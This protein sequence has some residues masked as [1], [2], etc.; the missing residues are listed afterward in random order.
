MAW[1]QGFINQDR[2]LVHT[3]Q[4]TAYTT[5][6]YGQSS[7]STITTIACYVYDE[8]Q[9]E[10]ASAP[11]STDRVKH[12]ALVPSSVTVSEGYHLSAVD[13][14]GAAVISQS[15]VTNVQDFNSHLYGARIKLLHLEIP[16]I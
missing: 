9:N 14:D 1:A 16:T 5:D 2:Y 15:Q 8:N 3:G 13:P 4:L 11:V 6:G 12:F 7:A 10:N